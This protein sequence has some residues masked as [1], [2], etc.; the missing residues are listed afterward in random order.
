M[1]TAVRKSEKPRYWSAPRNNERRLVT[2]HP[3]RRIL[4]LAAG[5]AALP[6]ASRFAWAQTYPT[7]PARLIVGA[8][9]GGLNDIHARLIAEWLSR[10]F[11]RS[12]VVEN[13]PGAAGNIGAEA[14]VRAAPD[15][16]TL[17]LAGASDVRNE[18]LYNDLKFSFIRDTA[19]VATVAMVML[20]LVVH[21]SFSARSVPEL[22]AAAKANPDAMTVA[23]AG[24]GS[25]PH[26]SWELFRSMTGTRMLHVPY[27]GGAPALADLLGQQVQ[28][29]FAGIAE[30]I[31]YV[32]AGKLRALAVTGATRPQVLPD[33]PTI[34]EFVP[35]FEYIGWLGVVAP[36]D[37]P[38]SI[39]DMLNKAI[40]AG[41][42]DPKIKQSIADLGETVFA[43]SPA[44][45]GKFIAAE[46]EKWGKVIRAANI[47]L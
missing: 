10:Q 14:V 23:S 28:V 5:A 44:E 9:P 36:R 46:N 16:Y 29:Y 37:T 34:S 25:A 40:N 21:P 4:S 3:R 17:F 32:K 15:G 31:E 30:A 20:V 6:A 7:R 42:A 22:I 24:V 13:R 35:G 47:K 1:R 27:R 38:P 2:Q 11:G 8:P 26:V 18:I 19:P 39:I 12:F 45:F 41:L 43:S 33:V